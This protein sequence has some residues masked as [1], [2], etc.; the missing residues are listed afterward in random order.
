MGTGWGGLVSV[1]KGTI[2]RCYAEG[3]IYSSSGHPVGGLAYS[4]TGVVLDCYSITNVSASEG[5]SNEVAGLVSS[6]NG[7]IQRCYS[8]GSVTGGSESFA[9]V[10]ENFNDG[11][12]KYCFWDINIGG[13][14]GIEEAYGQ[15][16]YVSGLSTEEMKVKS[17]FTDATW[18]FDEVWYIDEGNDYPR[19]LDTEERL[20]A[21]MNVIASEDDLTKVAVTWQ[22][23]TGASFYKVYRSLAEDENKTALSDWIDQLTFDDSTANPGVLYYYW[24]KAAIST[25]GLGSSE[26]STYDAGYRVP[27]YQ[28]VATVATGHGTISPVN[29]D[30]SGGENC[31]LNRLPNTGYQVKSWTGT[32]DDS[33]TSTTNTVTMDSDKTVT[34]EFEPIPY[35]LTAS[36]VGG[37]GSIAPEN[38]TY[39]YGQT[40]TLTATPDTGYRVKSWVGTDDDASTSNTNTI[41]MDTDKTVTVE[42]ELSPPQGQSLSIALTDSIDPVSVGD[43]VTYTVTYGNIGQTDATGAVITEVLPEGLNFVSASGGGTYSGGTITWSIGTLAGETSGQT[44]TF[45]VQVKDSL[46]D[47]GTITHRQ[48]IINC[49]EAAFALAPSE[50]TTVNDTQAPQLGSLQPV[51]GAEWVSCEPLIRLSLTDGG[52]GC[53]C[54]CRDDLHRGLCDLYGTGCV[55]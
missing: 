26:Y 7:T 5:V 52:S 10:G 13:E 15:V 27:L 48:L 36:V 35:T 9:L 51:A 34:V 29:G 50:T 41:T 46:A 23:V 12:V 37:H 43:Q 39:D 11:I 21:P 38:D 45:T 25:S 1:N 49:N 22:S 8:A 40:A 17:N 14:Q 6:N 42:F 47:G 31:H 2:A 53:G 4:N 24:I 28:L 20:P 18:D 30:Y 32:D 19:L 33:S 44:V 16:A 3:S 54:Q 55:L